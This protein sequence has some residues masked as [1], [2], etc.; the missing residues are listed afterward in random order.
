MSDDGGR[1]LGCEPEEHPE[2]NKKFI[3]WSILRSKEWDKLD[4][5]L[6]GILQGMGKTAEEKNLTCTQS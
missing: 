5:D 3:K 4:I 6:A 2:K 1:V